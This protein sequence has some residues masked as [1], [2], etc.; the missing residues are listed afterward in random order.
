MDAR[1]TT[2]AD[3]RWPIALLVG[4]VSAVVS[5][6]LCVWLADWAMRAH[7]VS[8]FEGGRAYAVIFCWVPPGFT[9]TLAAAFFVALQIKRRG[10]AGYLLKQVVGILVAMLII[11]AAGGIGY[12]TADHPPL[13]DGKNLALQIEVRVPANGRSVDDL[14][15]AGFEVALVVSTSD[16][17]YADLRWAEAT[18]SNEFIVVPAWA[19]LN[20]RN[21]GREIT[22]GVKDENRQIFNVMRRASPDI[23]ETWSD[24]EAPRE[25]F[26]GS[27]PAR[28][29]AYQVRY[30]VRFA[31]EYSPT[32]RPDVI[33]ESPPAPEE[34][35]T[36][37]ESSTP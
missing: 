34:T 7:H 21:A 17:N 36:P 24:W 29:D 18:Q 3:K 31:E 27:K 14:K 19:N 10:F 22:V 16:R 1:P 15:K 4:F 8:N 5:V 25:R 9:V 33:E 30:R 12:A 35:S 13:I 32:P 11:A 23:D 20:S 28:Q 6:P 26:D 2:T 37:N